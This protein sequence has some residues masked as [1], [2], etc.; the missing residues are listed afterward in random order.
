MQD[1][2]GGVGKALSGPGKSMPVHARHWLS[3]RK[4]G[5][6]IDICPHIPLIHQILSYV[7]Y[8]TAIAMFN[9]FF[10]PKKT[11]GEITMPIFVTLFIPVSSPGSWAFLFYSWPRSCPARSRCHQDGLDRWLSCLIH[12]SFNRHPKTGLGCFLLVQHIDILALSW[13]VT[14]GHLCIQGR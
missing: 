13:L 5:L 14:G 6:V 3:I 12:R 9:V 2:S 7:S 1:R 11:L 8:V 4:K 10:E